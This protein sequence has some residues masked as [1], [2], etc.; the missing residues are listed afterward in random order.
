MNVDALDRLEIIRATLE[1][2]G[3]VRSTALANEL[4]VS[5]MTIRRDLE[6]LADEGVAR[7]VRGGA[8]AIG[9]QDFGA[10]SREHTR[11]KSV[12]GQKLVS[13]VPVGGA[14]GIDASSTLQRLAGR[15]GGARDLTVITNGPDTFSVL[16]EQE[17][18]T[19]LLSGG[20]LDRRTGSLVGP[21]AVRAAREILL[22]K[23]FVSASAVDPVLGSSEATLEEAEVKIALAASAAE[24]VLA[25][26]ASKLGSHAPARTFALEQIATMVTD[27]DPKDS[28]LDPYREH[29]LIV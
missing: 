26:D 4:E 29:C 10:R 16:H 11:A 6:L 1:R 3:R 12:I 28:R 8:V 19:A 23:L 2:D 17:G 21:L 13:L 24:V 15:L 5:E 7:R 27:L 20:E 22:T 25:V 9:P 14:V 18:V